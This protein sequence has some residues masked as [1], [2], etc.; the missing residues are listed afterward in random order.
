[1]RPATADDRG[2]LTQMLALA[3]AWDDD[4]PIEPGAITEHPQ[5][6]R[7][8]DGWAAPGDV[9]V[10][11]Q[12]DGVGIGAAWARLLT[13]EDAG[14]GHV[15]DAVPEISMAVHP[16]H[17]GRGTGG[18]LLDALLGA[19]RAGG[20]AAASL[21][22]A[23]GNVV[24]RHLYERTGFVTVGR[25]GGSDTMLLDLS[26]AAATAPAAEPLQDP[27]GVRPVGL[28]PVLPVADL[29]AEV[30]F[31]VAL[32]FVTEHAEDGFVALAAGDVLFGLHASEAPVP[33]GLAWQI[34]VQDVAVAHRVALRQGLDVAEE[35]LPQPWGE[36][37]LRLRTPSGYLLTLEGPPPAR[38]PDQ[39]GPDRG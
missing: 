12:V 36:W 31:Y 19:L 26:A 22:V 32:G 23:D 25:S 18:R 7:Y 4:R 37:T 5:L 28:R 39:E 33:E 24:A 14:Y 15:S 10:V 8:V 2:L 35:P 17:R 34:A 11:A 21:S 6:S 20:T 16:E 9:G 13:G 29:V 27:L 3:V 30:G 38:G 1:M